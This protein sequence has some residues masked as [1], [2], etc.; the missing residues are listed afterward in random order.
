MWD[1]VGLSNPPDYPVN[2][3]VA[4]LGPR[5]RNMVL[6]SEFGQNLQMHSMAGVEAKAPCE[7]WHPSL[8]MRRN[9]RRF[10]GLGT[11]RSLVSR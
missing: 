10:H 1:T 4:H 8:P 11:G 3:Q 7:F 9:L 5:G 2:A 6:T